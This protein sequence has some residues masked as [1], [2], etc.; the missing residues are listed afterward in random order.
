MKKKR[1][2]MKSGIQWRES[3]SGNRKHSCSHITK[4]NSYSVIGKETSKFLSQTVSSLTV[5]TFGCP[6]VNCSISTFHKEEI[7]LVFPA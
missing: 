2:Q 1:P 7:K 5:T 6:T 4:L 3:W